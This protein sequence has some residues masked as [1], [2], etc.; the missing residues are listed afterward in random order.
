VNDQATGKGGPGLICG[1]SNIVLADRRFIVDFRC[2]NRAVPQKSQSRARAKPPRYQLETV[3]RACALL[4]EF[5]NDR[6]TLSLKDIMERTGLERTICFRL[7]RT[8]ESEGFL[9]RA[10]LRRY[11]SNLNILSSR[12]FRIGYAAEGP[13]SFST[14]VSQG[15]RWVARER[16]LDLIELDN[17]YSPKAALHNAETMIRERVN[18]AIEFQV[19][20][21]IAPRLSEL[22]H[23]AGIPVIALEIPQPGA[24]FF[25]VD[26]QKVGQIAGG[27][28]VRTAKKEWDGKFDQ[29]IL[30]DL[31][32]AGSVPHLRLSSTQAAVRKGLA[33]DWLTIHLDTRGEFV[34]A[35]EVTRKHLQFAKTRRTLLAGVNDMAVLGAL[36]AFEES[37]CGNLCCAV[38]MGGSPEA[39]RELRL[40]TSRLAG[41]V[42][43]FP[44]RYGNHVLDLALEILQHKKAP[45]AVYAQVELITPQNVDQFYPK[46]I[47]ACPGKS[48][49]SF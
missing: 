14:A 45:P 9:R 11:A 7:L 5:G 8:L 39:C 12:R 44:E 21:R 42:G 15:L 43:F 36:R 30:L 27:V 33:G 37:G 16:Q 20:D 10:E 38:G 3:S 34:R 48:E 4:R 13:N 35:F 28:L 41:S 31:E 19:Y 46:D 2:Y 1:N 23:A 22:F 18:L 49:I 47:F 25:G 6:K 32:I 26:N 24:V 40:P 29:L 17:N